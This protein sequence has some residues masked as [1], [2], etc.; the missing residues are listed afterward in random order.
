MRSFRI[1]PA[2]CAALLAAAAFGAETGQ[3]KLDVMG[4]LGAGARNPARVIAANGTEAGQVAPGASIALPPGNYRLVLPIVGGEIVKD[5]VQIEA[6]RTHT[7]RIENVAVLEVSVKNSAGKDPGF[8]VTVTAA[9]PPH[10]KMANFLTGDKIL[11]APSAV[12][13]HADAPPQGYDWNAVALAPGHRTRLTLDAIVAAELTVQPELAGVDI[14]RAARVVVLRAGTQHQ[15]AASDPGPAHRFKLQPGDYDIFVE[16]RSGKGKP[17]TTISGVHLESG[18][19]VE[20]TAPL[21]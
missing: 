6:G 7:V 15:V 19:R 14:D 1:L 8:G 17:Y 10:A 12:D 16:N 4:A 20:R 5:E 13:V 3:L 18:A 9:D 2:L 11:F 21:D